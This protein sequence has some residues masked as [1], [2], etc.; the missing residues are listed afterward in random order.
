MYSAK[1]AKTK[2]AAKENASV[3]VNRTHLKV[4]RGNGDGEN[5]RSAWKAS[6][7]QKV[8]KC[9]KTD[10]GRSTGHRNQVWAEFEH[11]NGNYRD[12]YYIE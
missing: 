11:Q 10:R 5:I 6:V 2:Q 1:W 4:N 12:G 7:C 3:S 9:S 8:K